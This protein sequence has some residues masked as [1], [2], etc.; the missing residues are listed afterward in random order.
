MSCNEH[1]SIFIQNFGFA[2]VVQ[3]T[4]YL[5]KKKKKILACTLNFIILFHKYPVCLTQKTKWENE[6]EMRPKKI[7]F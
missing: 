5:A 6:T 4:L 1:Q 7:L 3:I 2:K